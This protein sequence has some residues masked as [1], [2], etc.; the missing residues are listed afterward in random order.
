MTTL[1]IA[2]LTQETNFGL[3]VITAYSNGKIAAKIKHGSDDKTSVK[4]SYDHA[5]S[6]TENH[7]NAAVKCLEKLSDEHNKKFEIVYYTYSE[8]DTGYLFI[9]KRI[10]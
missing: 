3:S 2:Q 1:S 7:F 6:S 4:V 8:K 5:M 10:N 9:V